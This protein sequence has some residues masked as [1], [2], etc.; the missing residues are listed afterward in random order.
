MSKVIEAALASMPARAREL[1]RRL[2]ERDR[3]RHWNEPTMWP[4]V[5]E[6]PPGEIWASGKADN[7]DR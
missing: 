3:D 5:R 7:E 4:H 2:H 1:L 6:P